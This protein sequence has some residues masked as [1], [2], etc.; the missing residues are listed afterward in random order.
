MT[1]YRELLGVVLRSCRERA[2]MSP[3]QM[4]RTLG[5]YSSVKIAKIEAGTVKLPENELED[6]LKL[7]E[8]A[9]PEAAKLRYFGAKARNRPESGRMPTAVNTYRAFVSEA[10]EIKSYTEMVLPVLAQTE[11]YASA[12]FATSLSTPPSEIGRLARE[13][14][15]CQ[16]PL[17][18]ADPP[19]LHI[20]V[21]EPALLRPIG[22]PA[23]RRAQ[24]EHL[25]E[26]A[27]LSN[28]TFQ[29]VPLDRGEHSGLGTPFTVLCLAIP[30]FTTVYTERLTGSAYSDAPEEVDAYQLAFRRISEVALNARDSVR[31]L[32]RVL[33][34]VA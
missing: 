9:D 17:V 33:E 27:G 13:R 20:V 15:A 4:T 16:L 11:A 31:V 30:E 21:G 32:D 26:L 23:V 24:L 22:G 18:S 6:L 7:Y 1:A 14:V 2:G 29:V 5:W 8:V 28:V 3:T 19:S 10:A 25:H 12:L 34:R